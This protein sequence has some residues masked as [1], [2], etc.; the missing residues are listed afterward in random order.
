MPQNTVLFYPLPGENSGGNLTATMAVI[1]ALILLV[2]F[3]IFAPILLVILPLAWLSCKLE[4][5]PFTP[6]SNPKAMLTDAERR[7]MFPHETTLN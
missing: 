5:L 7:K 1:P 2:L 4:G 6:L 3:A